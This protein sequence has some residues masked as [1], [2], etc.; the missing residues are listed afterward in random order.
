MCRGWDLGRSGPSR[1]CAILAM[2]ASV[3]VTDQGAS[4]PP[5]RPHDAHDAPKPLRFF[6]GK[7][8]DRRH[9]RCPGEGLVVNTSTHQY[10]V[11]GT[12]V[13]PGFARGAAQDL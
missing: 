11:P 3:A 4:T 12:L 10:L 13:M 7:F 9:L 5:R 6:S 2:Y 1:L 8:T